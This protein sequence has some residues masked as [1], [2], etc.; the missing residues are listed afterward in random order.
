MIFQS[1]EA[2]NWRAFPV[3]NGLVE[4]P[5]DTPVKPI[6][7][8]PVCGMKVAPSAA[9]LALDHAGHRYHFCAEPCR[10]KFAAAPG[11]YLESADPVCG[12]R[13]HRATAEHFI[14][15]AGERYFF[16]SGRC[17]SRFEN[18]PNEFLEGRLPPPGPPPPGARYTCPMDPE[19]VRD[20]PG[21][22][23][24]CGMAL[25][26]MAPTREAGPNP[27]LVDF[28]RRLRIGGPLALAT[29]VLEMGGHVGIPL[30]AWL[31]PHLHV[32]LLLLLSTP[33]VA[34]VAAPFF[35]RGWSS[36]VNRRLN[37]WTLI[38]L[39]AGASY[40]FS[41]AAVLAPG[42]FPASVRGP[43]GLPPV[44]FEAAAV[45]LILVL[46]G[47][48]LELSARERTGG[49]IRALLDLAPKFARRVTDEGGEDV[50]LET[51]GVGDRL[52]VRPGE[53]IPVDGMVVGGRS[54]VDESMLTG[55][56]LPVDKTAGD[57][58]TGGTLNRSGAFTM[59]AERV[60]A[61]TVLARMVDMVAAAQRSRAPVQGLVD[62]VSSWFVPAVVGVA[63]IAFVIWLLVGPEPALPHAL[64]VAVSVLVIACPC[65]LGLA[66]PMSI[67]VASGRGAGAGVLIRDAAALEGLAR[68]DMLVVDKTGTVTAGT[69]E[70]TDVVAIE[71]G[72][73]EAQLLALGAS[74]ERG[75]EHPLATAVVRGAE[76]R[77]L[78]LHEPA[79][80][81][82]IPGK[83]VRGRVAG[84][85]VALGNAALMRELGIDPGAVSS[86]VGRLQRA[87]KT[88]MHV[89]VDGELQGLVAAAD[90]PRPR[91]RE[92]LAGL[93]ALGLGIVMA[94]GDSELAARAIV[95]EIEVDDWRAQLLPE[96]K[97]NLVAE[98]RTRGHRV[99]MAGDGINDAP[100][101]ATADVGIAMGTGADVAIESAGIT[102]V[103]GD[104]TG[105]VRAVRLARA[106]SSN[107]RQNLLFAF[108]YN[109]F[110][111]S[112][113]AGALYPA[114]GVLLS[115]IVAAAAMSLSSVSVIG[116][117]LRL[118]TVLLGDPSSPGEEKAPGGS[119]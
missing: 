110:G 40:A 95:R 35:R 62:R 73:G 81:E 1:L 68:V 41:V 42:F 75:S 64:V 93:R 87:G 32:W 18:S 2:L 15:H 58:V 12:M 36:V 85:T 80:L 14:S 60:G 51:I 22:C 10:T 108:A 30:V 23:P 44:Y 104:L 77:G 82:A 52:L 76:A 20:A 114:F 118:R 29:L 74:L 72:I 38:A 11:E 19:I 43:H 91:A 99:A 106:T 65:A 31:G 70:L 34:W 3:P 88:V 17:R 24:I 5:V 21:D 105:I 66:T 97:S 33:V 103:R 27:E 86:D 113:A 117:A 6:A 111:V 37:M 116:N 63:A 84:R 101:L 102:L 26:P 92:A 56:A 8:D 115:P 61:Q 4:S 55:E 48:I 50:P 13:V 28:R 71:G 46:V 45:I 7:R 57:P 69:P 16:C 49:A 100:A 98:L 90:R 59:R 83:G 54:A 67:M 39:G 78:T 119:R 79:D 53:S 47:Q 89:V 9:R 96:D 25:E 107:I 94:T 112:I 109:V